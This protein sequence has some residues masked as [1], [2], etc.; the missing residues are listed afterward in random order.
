MLRP[1]WLTAGTDELRTQEFGHGAYA[2]VGSAR[3]S[4]LVKK[5]GDVSRD[6]DTLRRN[7]E[8]LLVTLN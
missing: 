4:L 3:A 7:M 8:T 6:R 5:G 2:D 1:G